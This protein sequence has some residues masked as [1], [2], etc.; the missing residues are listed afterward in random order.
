MKRAA[1]ASQGPEWLTSFLIQPPVWFKAAVLIVAVACLVLAGRKVVKRDL[2]ISRDEQLTMQVLLGTALGVAGGVVISMGSLSLGYLGDVLVGVVS[3]F[4]VV[5]TV[6]LAAPLVV[7]RWIDERE[8][9]LAGWALLFAGA[10]AIP[11]LAALLSVP[12]PA[13]VDL[14]VGG[15]AVAMLVWTVFQEYGPGETVADAIRAADE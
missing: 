3:G 5:D 9:L 15:I 13:G 6:R 11:Q 8:L 1:E 14:G 7:G 2:F 10:F 4:L 12:L